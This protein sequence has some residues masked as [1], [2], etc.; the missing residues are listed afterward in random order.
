MDLGDE[1]VQS[2]G[3]LVASCRSRLGGVSGRKRKYLDNVYL[4]AR[5]N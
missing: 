1:R 3:V 5:G 2:M 4:E